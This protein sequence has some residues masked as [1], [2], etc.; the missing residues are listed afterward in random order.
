MI[1]KVQLP[2]YVLGDISPAPLVYDRE[3]TKV[4]MQVVPERVRE[5]IAAKGKGYFHAEFVGREYVIGA[6]AEEQEW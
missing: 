5:A 3:R 4:I 1:V 2:I 6:P